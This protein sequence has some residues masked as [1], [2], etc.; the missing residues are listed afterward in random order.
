MPWKKSQFKAIMANTKDPK[1]REKYAKEQY[2]K[3]K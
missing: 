1:K 3:K 2:G